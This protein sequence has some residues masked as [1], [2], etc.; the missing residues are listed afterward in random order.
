MR[1]EAC[2]F[3][4]CTAEHACFDFCAWPMQRRRSTRARWLYRV[5]QILGADAHVDTAP[6]RSTLAQAS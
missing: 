4:A 3:D 5:A 1:S 6:N 2:L